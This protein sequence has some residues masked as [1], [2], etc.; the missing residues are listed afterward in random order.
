M[1]AKVTR[2]VRGTWPDGMAD[3]LWTGTLQGD[4]LVL[5]H[6][7]KQNLVSTITLR[8]DPDATERAK[9]GRGRQDD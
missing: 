7:G 8:L 2:I 3:D 5:K 6:T 9:R 4:Q 1:A